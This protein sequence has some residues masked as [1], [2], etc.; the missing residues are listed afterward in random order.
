MQ[1]LHQKSGQGE[2][3][4]FPREVRSPVQAFSPK[5][6][7]KASYF[8]DIFLFYILKISLERERWA[9]GGLS[10]MITSQ[11]IFTK[12]SESRF[13]TCV[14]KEF[15]DEPCDWARYVKNAP[16]KP[17]HNMWRE[18]SRENAPCSQIDFSLS[19]PN[20][21]CMSGIRW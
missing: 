4:V 18:K 5:S 1:V 16:L 17:I 6:L 19:Q 13:A 2:E 7:S 8:L 9:L 21:P 20:I 14:V 10:Q 11:N 15:E 12:Y 3:R